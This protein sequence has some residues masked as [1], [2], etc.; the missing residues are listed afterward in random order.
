M[1]GRIVESTELEKPGGKRKSRQE[2]GGGQGLVKAVFSGEA[3]GHL[4]QMLVGQ[5]EN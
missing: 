3:D 2:A 5:D 1:R 4:D